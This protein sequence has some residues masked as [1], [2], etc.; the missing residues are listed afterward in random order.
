MNP[1]S[2][3]SDL[4]KVVEPR[5]PAAAQPEQTLSLTPEGLSAAICTQAGI[6]LEHAGKEFE[7]SGREL[8]APAAKALFSEVVTAYYYLS[9][10]RLQRL[11]ESDQYNLFALSLQVSL[12]DFINAALKDE[13]R[14]PE[15]E[16]AAV[17]ERRKKLYVDKQAEKDEL[18]Y[19]KAFMKMALNE[20]STKQY[21]D[22][23]VFRLIVQS[24]CMAILIPLGFPARDEAEDKPK[25][26]LFK[27]HIQLM[28]NFLNS[29]LLKLAPVW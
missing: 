1:R 5:P 23:P 26:L 18:A 19:L 24:V 12:L 3:L 11:L 8:T 15:E 7:A 4:R 25:L 6:Y 10:M 29:I 16:M 2:L 17:L 22:N 27:F 28:D 9:T 14:I 20:E 21:Y 13:L